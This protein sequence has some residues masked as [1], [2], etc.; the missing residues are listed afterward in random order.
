MT[1]IVAR[2]IQML[3]SSKERS[4]PSTAPSKKVPI[5]YHNIVETLI[6]VEWIGIYF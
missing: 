6:I 5:S 1:E 2:N 3:G 4:E